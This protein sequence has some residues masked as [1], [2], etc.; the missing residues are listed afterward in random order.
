MAFRIVVVV[1]LVVAAVAAAGAP[2]EIRA[3]VVTGGHDFD[4]PGFDAL[5]KG[6]T[7]VTTREVAH[8][9]AHGMLSAERSRDYDVLVFYDM[10]QDISEQ[11]KADLVALLKKGKGLIVLH[12][13]LA[14]YQAWDEYL[15]IA[16]GRFR[17]AESEKDGVKRPAS[18][19]KDDVHIRAKVADRKHPV[20]RGVEDFEILD[21]TY[22]DYEVLPKVK[23]LL[24]TDE[25]TSTPTIAWAH[26]YGRSRVV[27]MQGGHGPSAWQNPSFRRLLEQ[28]VRWVAGSIR[29]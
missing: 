5:W 29:K 11:A 25:P 18:T 15:Q 20:T 28:A 23:A 4:R 19:W 17:L 10:H 12:H 8:P 27:T 26:T 21:E 13:A 3:L 1:A 16:G 22:G 7:G 6:L 2:K 9:N 24:T 14:N